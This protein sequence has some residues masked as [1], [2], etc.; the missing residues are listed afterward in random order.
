MITSGTLTMV[1]LLASSQMGYGQT[2]SMAMTNHFTKTATDKGA[3]DPT[4][5]TLSMVDSTLVTDETQNVMVERF[6]NA[7]EGEVFVVMV[8]ATAMKDIAQYV[9]DNCDLDD[10]TVIFVSSEYPFTVIDEASDAT[11]N[12][13]A[14][15]DAAINN[16][17][18]L[19]LCTTAGEVLQYE[20]VTA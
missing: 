16:E 1:W 4:V 18:G 8:G 5:I 17:S 10:I 6:N 14:A 9:A 13:D 15:I 12:L 11:I 2:P 19:Y 3:T 7:G 20:P